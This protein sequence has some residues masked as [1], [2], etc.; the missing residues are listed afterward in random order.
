MAFVDFLEVQHIKYWHTNNEMFTKS[1]KQ[2][3]RSKAMGTQSGIPDLFICFH[4]GIVGFEMK[5]VQGGVVS[6]NQKLWG[7]ILGLC[8]IKV[9][10]C[11]G[12]DAA[13]TTFNFLKDV[14]HYHPVVE[15]EVDKAQEVSLPNLP[16]IVLNAAGKYEEKSAKIHRNSTKSTKIQKNELPY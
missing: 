3:T 1:W 13:V 15:S 2:K 7:V 8:G 12:A 6:E 16:E 11:R 14:L 9:Y 5:R 10:C 4:E